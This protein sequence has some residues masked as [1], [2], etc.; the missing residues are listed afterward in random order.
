MYVFQ[1]TDLSHVPPPGLL[2]PD[3]FKAYSKIKVDNHAFNKYVGTCL[4]GASLISTANRI[5]I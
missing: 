1:I 5:E 4:Y 3:D 2:M